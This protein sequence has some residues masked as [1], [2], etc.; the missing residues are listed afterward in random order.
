MTEKK[1]FDELTWEEWVE[2]GNTIKKTHSLLINESFKYPKSSPKAR[3]INSTIKAIV[4]VKDSLDEIL[5]EK[6]S[7]KNT[8]E[9]EH[10]FYGRNGS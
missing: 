1:S 4:R 10:I 3:K 9:L 8:D 7:D 6:F 5:H 2:L